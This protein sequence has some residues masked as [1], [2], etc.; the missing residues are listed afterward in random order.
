[1]PY[2][3]LEQQREYQRQW[4]ARRRERFLAGKSCAFCGGNEKLQVHHFDPGAK[5]SHRIWSWTAAKIEA[6]LAKCIFLCRTCH[7]RHHA[8]ASRPAFCQRG[9]Q[10]TEANTYVKPGTGRRECRACRAARRKKAA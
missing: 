5:E 9:H 10:F 2:S 8:E 4:M 6:E 7:Q 1:M 3:D